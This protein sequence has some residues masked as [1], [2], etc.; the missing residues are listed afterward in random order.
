MYIQ[1]KRPEVS[2]IHLVRTKELGDV[3]EHIK[4]VSHRVIINLFLNEW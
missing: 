4:L 3:N 1:I 2:K